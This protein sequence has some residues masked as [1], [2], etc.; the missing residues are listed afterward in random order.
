[1]PPLRERQIMRTSEEIMD[2]YRG[3]HADGSQY[4]EEY[5]PGTYRQA[6]GARKKPPRRKRQKRGKPVWPWVLLGVLALLAVGIASMGWQVQIT[7]D[8]GDRIDAEYGEPFE[9]P[10][11]KARLSCYLFPK[12]LFSVRVKTEGTVSTDA[13]GQSELTYRAQ[14]LWMHAE[15]TRAIDVIDT[16]P[17]VI[18]LKS[19]PEH[20]TLSNHPYE[21]EGYTAFDRYDGDLTGKVTSEERDGHVYYSVTDSSGNTG[22]AVREIQYYDPNPPELT[23]KGGDVFQLA[24]GSEYQE[25]GY[26]AVDDCDG[27]ITDRVQV[28]GTVD[29]STV[30]E[31]TLTYTV[32]DSFGNPASATRTVKVVPQTETIDPGDKVIY[33]TFDDGP[34]QYTAQLLDVLDKYGVKATFFVVNTGYTDLIADEYKRGHTVAV[35]TACHDYDTVYA[36]EDAY[37]A[38]F[39]KMQ[40]IID[41]KT[42]GYETTMFR[43]PGGSSNTVSRFNPGIMTRLT[44]DA[45]ARG[46]QYYDWNVSSGDAGETTSTDQV[47]QNVIDGCSSHNVSIVLQHDIKGFSVAAVERIIQWGLAN[48]Y[49][50]LPL[51]PTSPKA[52]HGINN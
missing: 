10:G 32:T 34:S 49:T 14:F 9:D 48:G 1:M 22:T 46:L 13:L 15:K 17:P 4:Y 51:T 33:L 28:E 11:V 26:E 52:H 50:F 43:F 23:L 36:S 41:D 2:D 44:Q 25:P 29:S 45:T 47:Y 5:R 35:H 19:D 7:L 31:Y 38:D 42:G 20:R 37:F 27:D 8:G 39:S 30:G 21:E 18:T 3:S 6:S 40:Q 16:T 24:V 12:G